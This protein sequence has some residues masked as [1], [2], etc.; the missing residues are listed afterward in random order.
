MYPNWSKFISDFQGSQSLTL[1]IESIYPLKIKLS[2]IDVLITFF[3]D[4]KAYLN[5]AA[6]SSAISGRLAPSKEI[7]SFTSLSE[8]VRLQIKTVI[9]CIFNYFDSLK[10]SKSSEIL[11]NDKILDLLN[12]L[13]QNC[14]LSKLDSKYT[15]R[16]YIILTDDERLSTSKRMDCLTSM[17]ENHPD[18]WKHIYSEPSD[19]FIQTDNSSKVYPNLISKSIEI[20]AYHLVDNSKE[21]LNDYTSSFNFLTVIAKLYPKFIKDFWNNHGNTPCG[22]SILDILQE[23]KDCK[24]E[25]KQSSAY[26]FLQTLSESA[27]IKESYDEWDHKFWKFLLE[28]YIIYSPDELTSVTNQI[29]VS[30][31]LIFSNIPAHILNNAISQKYQKLIIKTSLLMTINE[32]C[33]IRAAAFQALGSLVMTDNIVVDSNFI[34]ELSRRCFRVLEEDS[35]KVKTMALFTAGNIGLSIQKIKKRKYEQEI[36]IPNHIVCALINQSVQC[37][38]KNDKVYIN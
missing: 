26:K 19:H 13:L 30:T 10:F 38:Q 33:D 8:K 27:A 16:I 18:F 25:A 32:H 29:R 2:A 37:C 36:S 14:P 1:F 31:V 24:I 20:I 5:I 15:A 34:I 7:G 12:I 23:I 22:K 35:L 3:K 6:G 28:N 4:S 21:S 17:T 9:E 11:L